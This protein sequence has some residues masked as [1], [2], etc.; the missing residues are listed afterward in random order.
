MTA[1]SETEARNT[2]PLILLH[3][4]KASKLTFKG[5]YEQVR[6]PLH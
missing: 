2:R 1:L 6:R 3:D 4:D 5:L